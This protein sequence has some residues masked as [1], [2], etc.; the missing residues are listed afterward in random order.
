M[1]TVIFDLEW[2]TGFIDGE[3]F[4]EVIEIGAVRVDDTFT[5]TGSF[6]ELIRPVYYRKMNPFIQK[7][8]PITMDDLK[9]AKPF[10]TVVEKFFDWCGE[11]PLLIAWSTNDFGVLEKNLA[12]AKLAFP[13]GTKCYDLQAAY[14]YCTEKSI[15][16]Y[17]LKTAVEAMQLPAPEEQTFHDAYYDALYTAAIGRAL[18][19]SYGTLPDKAELEAF[20]ATQCKPKK[21]KIPLKYSVKKAIYSPQNKYF[22]CPI[23]GNILKL[24]SWFLVKEDHFISELECECGN[25]YY[26]ELF[27]DH[28][29]QSRCDAHF[30]L[31][32]EG[33]R[34]SIA[35]FQKALAENKEICI[36]PYRGRNEKQ[37]AVS[38]PKK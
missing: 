17:S 3:S 24:Q 5:K 18:Q 36:Y 7:I 26:P 25:R 21:E 38:P 8:I 23:C 37:S 16:S 27:C 30:L 6:Q 19:K 34:E 12:K 10:S 14:S 4:D 20:R 35:A 31:W 2:N 9:N 15:R 33:H 1:S 13:Q 28:F 22:P 11:E 29:R 32:G